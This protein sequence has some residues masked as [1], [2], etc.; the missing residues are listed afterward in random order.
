MT[1]TSG[2]CLRVASWNVLAD[3]YI[4][5]DWFPRS[6]SQMLAPGARIDAVLELA[7]TL[8]A[9]VL[10]FQEADPALAHAAQERL[11]GYDVRWCPKGRGRADGCLSA[12]RGPWTITADT[13]H[14]YQDGFGGPN[15]GHVAHIL[16]LRNDAGDTLSVANT[17]LRF[18]APGT[19]ADTHVGVRQA[20]QLVNILTGKNP[21][22]IAADTNDSPDGPVRA[23]LRAGGFH[24][25][26]GLAPASIVAGTQIQALDIVT[27]R[28]ARCTALPSKILVQPPLPGP[29][30]PS[31]HVPVLATIR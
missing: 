5:A 31:D 1:T 26:T 8:D 18:A 11:T 29:A 25:A 7:M 30:C 15:S 16:E 12:V 20:R 3:A 4:Q 9:D 17:H 27:A 19:P 28:G 24:E 23:A 6:S 13:R 14:L 21:A 10:A 2:P 22:V